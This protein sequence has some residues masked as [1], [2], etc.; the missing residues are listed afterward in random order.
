MLVGRTLRAWTW[1]RNGLTWV[2]K[3]NHLDYWSVAWVGFLWGPTMEGSRSGSQDMA[4][5]RKEGSQRFGAP[6]PLTLPS[7]FTILGPC[8]LC[9]PWALNRVS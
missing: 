2:T 3:Y 7:H 8:S 5:I 9:F 1:V 6:F 4:L